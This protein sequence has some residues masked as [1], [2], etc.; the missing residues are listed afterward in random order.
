MSGTGRS[1]SNILGAD[2]RSAQKPASTRRLCGR[3]KIRAAA[4]KFEMQAPL[5][6]SVSGNRNV[7]MAFPS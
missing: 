7:L 3:R 2:P 6:E 5:I 1:A 4:Q